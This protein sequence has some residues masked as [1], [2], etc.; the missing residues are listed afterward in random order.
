M[1]PPVS[2]PDGARA[3]R[4]AAG[5][6]SLT[7]AQLAPGTSGV[8]LGVRGSGALRGRLLE[9][10]FVSGTTVRVVRVAPLADPLEVELHGYHLS[11]RRADADTVLIERC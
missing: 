2:L 5:G 7:L 4:L 6:T 3:D 11:L 9:M 1:N 10:G 8:V